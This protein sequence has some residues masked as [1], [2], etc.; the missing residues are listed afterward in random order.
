MIEKFKSRKKKWTSLFLNGLKRLNSN[1]LNIK[2]LPM[3]LNTYKVDFNY[4]GI[5]NLIGYYNSAKNDFQ[6]SNKGTWT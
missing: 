2:I 4:I 6:N 5:N 3:L 1:H